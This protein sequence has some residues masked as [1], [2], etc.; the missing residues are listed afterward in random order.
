MS[1]NGSSYQIAMLFGR[2][3]D[4]DTLHHVIGE[5]CRN[6]GGL[7]LISGEAGIG[8]TTLVRSAS[9][10]ATAHGMQVHSSACYDL[11]VTPPYRPWIDILRSLGH[12]IT[13]PASGARVD[14]PGDLS[15]NQEDL[16]S[17]ALE[18]LRSSANSRPTLLVL[19]D[20]HWADTAS[21]EFLRF[22]ARQISDLPLLIFVTY[23]DTEIDRQ[24]SFYRHLPGL[25]RESD[26]TRLSVRPLDSSSVD[27]LLQS[28]Y[29]MPVTERRHLLDYLMQR[30]EGNPFFVDEM[31]R[32]LEENG[33]LIAQGDQWTVGELKH[34]PVPTLIRQVIDSRLERIEARSRETLAVAAV[35]GQDVPLEIWQETHQSSPDELEPA[36]ETG[37]RLNILE[38]SGST[39]TLRFT[40]ALIR[41]ALYHEIS[42]PQRRLLH[43]SIAETLEQR[44]SEQP[45]EIAWHFQQALDERAIKW[46]VDAG[47][48]AQELYAWRT[49]AERFA[50]ACELISGNPAARRVRAWLSYRAGMLLTYA[51]PEASIHWMQEAE[52]LA[53]ETEDAQLEAYARADRGLL[54]CLT[55]DVRRGL[56]ELKSGVETIDDLD[57]YDPGE[58]EIEIPVS[59]DAIRQK[60]VRQ[61]GT[62]EIINVRRG[63]L[64]LWLAWAGR[65]DEA[66]RVGEQF[67]E[68]TTDVAD[69]I[70][71]ARGDALAGLGHAHAAMGRPD[72]SLRAFALARETYGAI[73]HHFKVGNTAI[74][75]LSEAFL[76]YRAERIMQRQWLADQAEAY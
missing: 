2:E 31:L 10:F 69:E 33:V 8:K 41:E 20:F 11:S 71:D 14:Y 30:T 75:E 44:A 4:L 67:I 40:H 64:V 26:S 73:D 6:R 32:S 29:P 9:D 49:A 51:D 21:L 50:S 7:V 68:Q 12:Q 19:E 58:P 34:T 38:E 53:T 37:I 22:S 63:P 42:L 59:V 39:G 27:E 70:Q 28:R 5:A 13:I 60:T 57:W 56:S 48:R 45:D 62:T 36:I 17:E 16:F 54:R 52:R 25:V 15:S 74:Y 65:Y 24:H 23:R 55:G 66:I 43:R 76:P 46:L 18:L 72:D 1:G 3:R 47:E 61:I 35:I